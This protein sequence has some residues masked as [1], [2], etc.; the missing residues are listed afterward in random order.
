MIEPVSHHSHTGSDQARSEPMRPAEGA[1]GRS[2]VARVYSAVSGALGTVAG[3]TPHVLH[4]IGPIAGAAILTGTAGSILFGAIGFVLTVPLLLRL[5]R[6]FGS[7]LAPGIALAIFALMFTISSLWIGPAI[8]DGF[9]AGDSDT[10]TEGK[11]PHGHG[12]RPAVSPL[13]ASQL[14]PETLG[15]RTA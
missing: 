1:L 4:H 6:R 10:S 7:W 11:D 5:R 8:R 15:D 14:G 9:G 3:I 13:T 2:W 12:S